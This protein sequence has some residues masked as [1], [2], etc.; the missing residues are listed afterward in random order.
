V[1]AADHTHSIESDND[2]KPAQPDCSKNQHG[3]AGV[4]RRQI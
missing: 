4:T 1:P 2:G 3:L